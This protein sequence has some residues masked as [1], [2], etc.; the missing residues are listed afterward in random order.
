MRPTHKLLHVKFNPTKE[1]NDRVHDSWQNICR[2]RLRVQVKYHIGGLSPRIFM[3]PH[4]IWMGGSNHKKFFTYWLGLSFDLVQ[5]YL[6][7]KHSTILGSL[8]QRRKGL[9]STQEK[10]IQSEPY[11]EQD[12]FPPSTQSEDTN[13]VFIKTVDLTGKMYTDQTG[14][15][16]FTSIKGNKYIL[17]AY[18]YD[19]KTIH[20]KPQKNIR[21]RFNNSLPKTPQLIDQRRLETSPTYS[22][23][24]MSQFSQK[25]HQ[26]GK[27]NFSVSPAPHPS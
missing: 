2:E 9:R 20:V 17:V 7:K 4:S 26:G 15:F 21:P 13:L 14:R 10:V 12:Q 22:G 23:Q 5:K 3:D 25:N 27:R 16:P 24:W 6:S 19:S 8:Q 18:H 1:N 11:P